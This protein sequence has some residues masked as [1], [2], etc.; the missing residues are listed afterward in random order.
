VLSILSGTIWTLFNVGYILVLAFGPSFLTAQGF[1]VGIA[2]ATVSLVTWT[3]LFSLPLGGYLA[4]RLKWPDGIMVGCFLALAGAIAA[5][6]I[7]LHAAA[8]CAIIGLVAGPPAGLIMK[9]PTEVLRPENR[10]AGMGVFY[11]CFYAGMA[12]LVPL[13]GLLRDATQSPSAPLLFAAGVLLGATG[14]L[15]CFRFLQKRWSVSG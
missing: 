3:I 10:A 6:P 4:E 9:L 11:A 7:G 13:A 12:G 2:G 1:S 5:L 8:M 15:M 14:A